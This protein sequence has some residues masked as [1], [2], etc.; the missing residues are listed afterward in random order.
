MQDNVISR[1][2]DKKN[3]SDTN[4]SINFFFKREILSYEEKSTLKN[5]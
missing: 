2:E 1:R 4:K 3:N 5:D